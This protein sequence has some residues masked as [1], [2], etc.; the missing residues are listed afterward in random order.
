MTK[1]RCGRRTAQS[2]NIELPFGARSSRLSRSPGH[3]VSPRRG[4]GRTATDSIRPL[5]AL[6][7]VCARVALPFGSSLYGGGCQGWESRGKG[8][9][10]GGLARLLTKTPTIR[11]KQTEAAATIR[12]KRPTIATGKRVNYSN[13]DPQFG[14]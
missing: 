3:E 10:G 2:T 12:S 5:S 8:S 6:Y 1:D 4:R 11:Q 7:S 13:F 14:Q 9:A